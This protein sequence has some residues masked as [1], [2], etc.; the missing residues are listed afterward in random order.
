MEGSCG[1]VGQGGVGDRRVGS[2][3]A[4]LTKVSGENFNLSKRSLEDSHAMRVK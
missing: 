2:Y 1:L 4:F 3:V